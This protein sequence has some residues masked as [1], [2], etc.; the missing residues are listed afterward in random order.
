MDTLADMMEA[1]SERL[2]ERWLER[3]QRVHAPGLLSEP[4]LADH[5][6]DFLREVIAALRRE[7]EGEAP[8]THRVG[9]LGW[10][11]GEQRFRVGFEL[12]SVV[13]EYGALH[14]CIFELVE[15]RGHALLRLEEARILQQCFNRAVTD[16]VAHY[17]RMRE[18]ELLGDE[19]HPPTS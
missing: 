8:K 3:V 14:E 18:R 13:R 11:H 15:E 19:A 12:P 2:F 5:I 7:E 6:P 9:P 17:T 1:G 10:E 16:A 4:E